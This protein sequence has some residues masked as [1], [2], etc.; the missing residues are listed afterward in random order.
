M[1]KTP[2]E[3]LGHSLL[4]VSLH[5]GVLAIFTTSVSDGWVYLIYGQVYVIMQANIRC[6][7]ISL[8]QKKKRVE[9]GFYVHSSH[10]L[11]AR[12][13]KFYL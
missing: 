12:L 4:L 2:T 7:K 6:L 13:M 1:K 9:N 3:M 11:H 8:S 5:E 10:T